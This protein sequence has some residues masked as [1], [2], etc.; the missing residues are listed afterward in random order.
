[1]DVCA[2]RAVRSQFGPTAAVHQNGLVDVHL[3]FP[4]A[5]QVIAPS[6]GPLGEER[7]QGR[8]QRAEERSDQ[9]SFSRGQAHPVIMQADYDKGAV[10]FGAARLEDAEDLPLL[11]LLLDPLGLNAVMLALTGMAVLLFVAQQVGG[12]MLP[13]VVAHP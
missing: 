8:Y 4:D 3:A 6:G 12:V 5:S 9:G 13:D 7:G 11:A 1:M 2:S 10:L